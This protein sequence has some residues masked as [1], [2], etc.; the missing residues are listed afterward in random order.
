MT[1]IE[2]D[3]EELKEQAKAVEDQLG[4]LLDRIQSQLSSDDENEPGP[5]FRPV[6]EEK[7]ADDPYSKR[8]DEMFAQAEKDRSK[9]FELKKEL[10]RM[11]VFKK[12]EDRFLDLFRPSPP[13]E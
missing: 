1:G 9:A 5:E 4:E 13:Q 12:Y 2:I 8:I 6:P 3:L 7:A 11:G 10:D